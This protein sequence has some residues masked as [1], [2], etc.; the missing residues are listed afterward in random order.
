MRA[1]TRLSLE[2]S[3]QADNLGLASFGLGRA[4]SHM[5]V[6]P[7]SGYFGY[8][9]GCLVVHCLGKRKAISGWGDVELSNML[10]VL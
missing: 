4:D 3:T 10:P 1:G 7:P 2:V 9:R 6:L 5:A 8:L